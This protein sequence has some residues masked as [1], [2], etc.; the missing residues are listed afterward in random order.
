M[1]LFW[2]YESDIIKILIFFIRK[3]NIKNQKEVILIFAGIMF[4]LNV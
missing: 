3:F 2:H 1:T 4:I